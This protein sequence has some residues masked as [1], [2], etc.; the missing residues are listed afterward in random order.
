M[1]LAVKE[2][3]IERRRIPDIFISVNYEIGFDGKEWVIHRVGAIAVEARKA[4]ARQQMVR[5]VI[6]KKASSLFPEQ[7]VL[8]SLPM[9][10][11]MKKMDLDLAI[12][13]VKTEN[14]FLYVL[15]DQKR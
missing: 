4:G 5:S 6:R 7:F 11:Q 9:T 3:S 2:F 12:S 15:I 13:G 14:Q 8:P 1:R 10:P